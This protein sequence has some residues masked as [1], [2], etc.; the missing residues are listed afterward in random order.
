MKIRATESVK[1]RAPIARRSWIIAG[2]YFAIASFPVESALEKGSLSLRGYIKSLQS[3]SFAAD[4]DSLVSGNLLHNRLNLHFTPAAP[5]AA[6]LEGRNRLYYGE[7]PRTS[8]G[9]GNALARDPGWMDLSWTPVD[10]AGAVWN[11]ELDRAWMEW[12]ADR[13]QLRAGRQR[14]HWGMALAWN[15]NDLFN[16]YDFL[17][18]DYEERPG[19][20]AVRLQIYPALPVQIEFAAKLDEG[21]EATG[22]IRL[23]FN[24]FAYDL[25]ILAGRYKDDLVAGLGWA[26]NLRD[27]GFKGEASWFE[28]LRDSGSRSVAVTAG[29]DYV[30]SDG[31]FLTGSA[32][33]NS[34]ASSDASGLAGF[35]V[36]GEG[37]PLSPR[38]LFPSRWAF[39]A[40]GSR[41][42]TPILSGSLSLIYA[43]NLDG[44]VVMPSVSYGLAQ[45]WELQGIA[46]SFFTMGLHAGGDARV[47][48]NTLFLRLRWSF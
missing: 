7:I 47:L 41:S 42:F 16:A 30:F 12:R 5:Y 26:G 6:A 46:Q 21:R 2:F 4:L 17:D 40:Q 43:P 27:A 28:P 37:E 14:I 22:A 32:L 33:F 18:F 11:L 13:W 19:S 29:L 20:D 10:E 23:G 9:L 15:P 34:A 24:R 35:G 36:A 3:A 25:Q 8:P 39:L 48:A 31:L 1:V 38:N 45:N 44:W